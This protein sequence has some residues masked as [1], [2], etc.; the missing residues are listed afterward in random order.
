MTFER[1]LAYVFFTLRTIFLFIHS[2][3][4]LKSCK[5]HQQQKSLALNTITVISETGTSI[6]LAK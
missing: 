1:F 6:E 2:T 3:V 5:K 4:H